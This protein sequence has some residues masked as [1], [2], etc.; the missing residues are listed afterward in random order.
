[1]QTAEKP[2][3]TRAITKFVSNATVIY[4][5]TEEVI[6]NDGFILHLILWEK[7]RCQ[8]IGLKYTN[9]VIWNF[10]KASVVF[11]DYTKNLTTSDNSNKCHL[12]K[13]TYPSVLEP[14]M[15]FQGKK[16]AFLRNTA[17][18]HRV[19][20]IISTELRKAGCYSFHSYDNADLDIINLVV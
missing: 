9:Y 18:K 11:G 5:E 19:I 12:G 4:E 7:N 16:N 3:L 8:D 17:N 13:K 15:I 1:M 10:W 14:D 6:L 20:N 2:P